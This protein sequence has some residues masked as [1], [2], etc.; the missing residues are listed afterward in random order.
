MKGL[1]SIWI[2]GFVFCTQ[3]YGNSRAETKEE[4]AIAAKDTLSYDIL[5]SAANGRIVI[6]DDVDMKGDVCRLPKGMTLLFRKGVIRNGTLSGCMTKI[7][8]KGKAFDRVTIEGS[9]N[10]PEISTRLFA[11]L[12]YENS[13]RDVVALAH[14]KVKNRI[15]IEKGEYKVSAGKKSATCISLCSNTD[16]MMNGTIRLVPNGLKS[17]NIILAKGK[18][19][20]IGGKGTII[21]D[22]YTHTG[23]EGE[24]GMGVR[25]HKAVNATVSGLTIKDCWGDCIY[26][27]GNSKNVLIENC[28]LDNGRRQGISVTKADNVT[29]RRCSISNI[30]GTAPGYAID[31]EPNKGDSVDHVLI[32]NVVV[33]NCLG[34]IKATRSLKQTNEGKP[35][36]WIGSVEVRYCDT[37]AQKKFP[38]LFKGCDSLYVSNCKIVSSNAKPAILTKNVDHVCVVENTLVDRSDLLSKAKRFAKKVLQRG[39][40]ELISIEGAKFQKVNAN[41]IITE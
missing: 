5:G 6:N 29:I 25:L 28:T 36:S 21:G 19:I 4:V 7:E 31:I 27:G 41:R 16:L 20:N 39:S 32:D 37:S 35:L 3:S 38:A 17:Y 11:D 26:V 9:W 34:G 14:P 24:W 15:V 33:K 30:G 40:V 2:L 18:N 10:V 13:L 8:C 12:S 22:K 1:L 23:T